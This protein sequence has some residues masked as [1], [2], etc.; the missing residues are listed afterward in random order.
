MLVNHGAV[1]PNS[2]LP[3]L[4]A[5]R[6]PNWFVA[7]WRGDLSL[8]VSYWGMGFI[9][10]VLIFSLAFVAKVISSN[11]SSAFILATFWITYWSGAIALQ[12]WLWVG[13]WRSANNH[14]DRGGKAGWA[15]TAKVM[16]FLG[17]LQ[18]IGTITGPNGGIQNITEAI[19]HIDTIHGYSKY[20]VK[21]LRGGKEI[22][23]RGAIGEGI[24]DAFDKTIAANPNA[25][26]VQINST[27]G[28]LAEAKKIRDRIRSRGM[29]TYA[30]GECTSAATIIFMGGN[31]RF[32][33]NTAKMGFHEPRLPTI[34]GENLRAL[35]T[36]E[37]NYMVSSGVSRT[38]MA[39]AFTYKGP[40]VWYPSKNELLASGV[41]TGVTSGDE[42]GMT[43]I[44]GW[45]E[46]NKGELELL[47]LPV[48]R[49]L[50]EH[51]P[52]VYGKILVAFNESMSNNQSMADLRSKTIPLISGVAKRRLSKSSDD[53]L[54]S[55]TK[56][57]VA[58]I[59]AIVEISPDDCYSFIYPPKNAVAKNYAH[60][61]KA[62]L[63][64]QELKAMTEIIISY[65]TSRVIPTQSMTEKDL[66]RAFKIL[67]QKQGKEAIAILAKV[68]DPKAREAMDKRQLCTTIS[69]F[70]N[71][72]LT[73]PN[74]NAAKVLRFLYSGDE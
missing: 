20:E 15:T 73:L 6:S 33:A 49:A 19:E 14:V 68:G 8:G 43:A 39:K 40:D 58:E 17:I 37:E 64:E 25:R 70:Y 24:A 21:A 44:D 54:V 18:S 42:F 16:V 12:T 27:G 53:A 48:Y 10:Y 3:P 61:L 31:E 71:S 26:V 35:L 51:E 11:V 67:A 45:R 62:E 46:K 34:D 72:I 4:H 1:E 23:I 65:D 29:T 30:P 63:A 7:H 74:K 9:L 22:L 41:I 59:D 2:Q 57:L 47:K 32:M 36:D 60:Y 66:E 55:F 69:T 56:V 50:K 28:L 13:V 52:E 38:F 5:K